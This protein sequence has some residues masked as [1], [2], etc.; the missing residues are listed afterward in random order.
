LF[1]VWAKDFVLD[2]DSIT[3]LYEEL[4]ILAAIAFVTL[5]NKNIETLKLGGALDGLGKNFVWAPPGRVA[6]DENNQ[7]AIIRSFKDPVRLQAVLTAG[8]AHGSIGFLN[9]TLDQLQRHYT[10]IMMKAV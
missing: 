10:Y 2:K 1:I 6:F 7:Q 8:F 5:Q 9:E 4:E 3:L